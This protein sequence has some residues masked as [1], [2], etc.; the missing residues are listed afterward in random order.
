MG[1]DSLSLG[2]KRSERWLTI[3]FYLER[4]ELYLHFLLCLLACVST[5][6]RH[7]LDFED[8][9]NQKIARIIWMM[10][11]MSPWIRDCDNVDWMEVSQGHAQ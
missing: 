9:V 8:V 7:I 6:L 4:V 11:L 2:V 10:I 1:T 5:N 3:H